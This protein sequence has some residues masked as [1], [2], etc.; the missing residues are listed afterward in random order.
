MNR[1]LTRKEI[2]HD[3]F[4]ESVEGAIDYVRIHSRALAGGLI[5]LVV[6]ILIVGI[7]TAWKESRQAKAD[8][9]L[10]TA[11][12]VMSAPID[13][14]SPD[15][16][17]P[18]SPV[19]ADTA[20]RA[21]RS[22]ELLEAVRSDFG[23]SDA[24]NIANAYLGQIAAADGETSEAREL[25]ESFLRESDESLLAAEIRINLMSLDRAEGRGEELVTRLRA[26]LDAP[27]SKMP[28]DLLLYELGVTLESLA[29]EDEAGDA[30]R[31]IV[32][33]FPRSSYAAE[34]RSRT[35][36]T[37]TPLFSG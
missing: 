1:R 27:D 26:E 12:M 23:G 5:A 2:K 15:P 22:R 17:N 36:T 29:R 4:T 19:F 24:A 21:A 6:L 13:A 14:S 16:L 32:D 37:S 25:W 3:G 31:R 9:A 34:A 20:S 35:G 33:E 7:G 30:F 8:T 28:K 11:M 18:E 10:A